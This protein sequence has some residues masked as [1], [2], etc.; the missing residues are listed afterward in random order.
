MHKLIIIKRRTETIVISGKRNHNPM[1]DRSTLPTIDNAET[2]DPSLH[3]GIYSSSR[4]NERVIAT[5]V[6][7]MAARTL[8]A[9]KRLSG[10]TKFVETFEPVFS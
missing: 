2:R 7:N 10:I 6:N 1:L 5:R 8:T 4:T 3:S 9:Q